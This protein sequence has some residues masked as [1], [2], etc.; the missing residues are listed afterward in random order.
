MVVFPWIDGSGDW[1]YVQSVWFHWQSINVG[2]LAFISSVVAFN[3]S[4]F[5]ADR[6]R[7][8]NFITAKAFLPDALSEL[9]FYFE[10]SADLLKEAWDRTETRTIKS[11]L[12]T[13]LPILPLNYKKIFSRCIKYAESDVAEYLA[14]I[15]MRLQ[16]H[17][18]RIEDVCEIFNKGKSRILLSQSVISYLFRLA[19]LQAMAGKLFEYARGLESFDN[20]PLAWP[21]FK[22]AYSN[23][24]IC[25][26]EYD[27]LIWFT[28]KAIDSQSIKS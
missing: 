17:H 6:E 1:E 3:I 9:I 21:D 8:R 20:S 24:G 4:R 15:L 19:E 2:M 23:L 22:N 12:L 28:K 16:V 5:I 25:V 27:D 18:S 11:S 13:S 7:E 10:K 14:Y 26:N